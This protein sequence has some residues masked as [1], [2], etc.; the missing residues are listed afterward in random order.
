MQATGLRDFLRALF[1]TLLR[2]YETFTGTDFNGNKIE[3]RMPSP[4]NDGPGYYEF[5][6]LQDGGSGVSFC[7]KVILAPSFRDAVLDGRSLVMKQWSVSCQYAYG[8]LP[9]RVRRLPEEL[10]G[11]KDIE[12][13]EKVWKSYPDYN[14]EPTGEERINPWRLGPVVSGRSRA[15]LLAALWRKP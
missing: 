1:P 8:C 3:V 11:F 9:E 7:G 10:Q 15:A 13:V 2:K 6:W 4:E 14:T 5:E 12:V